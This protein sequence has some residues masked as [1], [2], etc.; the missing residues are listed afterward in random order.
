MGLG[1][2]YA[3]YVPL[4]VGKV[5]K[6]YIVMK[7]EWGLYHGGWPVAV[8]FLKADAEAYIRA[9]FPYNEAYGCRLGVAIEECELEPKTPLKTGNEVTIEET[10][11][12]GVLG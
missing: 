9:N 11:M 5:E 8:F 1:Y 2:L 10:R 12:S 4:D 3:P 6:V 7:S